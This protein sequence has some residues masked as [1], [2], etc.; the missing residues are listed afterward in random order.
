MAYFRLFNENFRIHIAKVRLEGLG[1]L[2][3]LRRVILVEHTHLRGLEHIHTMTGKKQKKQKKW[4]LPENAY[5]AITRPKHSRE[6]FQTEFWLASTKE[7]LLP[8][9]PDF[10]SPSGSYSRLNPKERRYPSTARK[11]KPN[12]FQTNTNYAEVHHLLRRPWKGR[13]ATSFPDCSKTSAT[14]ACSS[15]LS[16]SSRSLATAGGG[17]HVVG[18]EWKHVL[19]Q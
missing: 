2:K 18:V 13:S 3:Q 5:S 7:N 1:Q 14:Y 10:S 16:R 11:R 12:G 19:E 4:L 8:A 9:F 6:T 15:L 17:D